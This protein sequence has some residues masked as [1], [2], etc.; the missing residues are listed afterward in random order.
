[1]DATATERAVLV[2]LSLGRAGRSA[3]PSIP[4][5]SRA[6]SSS[7]PQYRSAAPV[8]GR[9]DPPVRRGAR[10]RRGL[11]EVQP[12]LLAARLPRLPRVLLLAD[13]H[14]AALDEA[15]R[16]LRRL[17]PR[18]RRR[19]RSSRHS[20]GLARRGAD[21]RPLRARALPGA[22][23]PGH[24]RRDHRPGAGS[25]L[26]DATGGGLVT[27]EGSGHGPHARDPVK[28]NLLLRD[29]VE[30]PPPRAALGAR[31]VAPQ[32]RALR[33]LADR[34]RA[35][36]ARRRDRRRAAQAASRPRDRL[37][38]AAPGDG[39][40]RGARRADPSRR[41]RT[42]RTSRAT[43]RASRP[44][45]TCTASRRSG[46]WTR[47]CSRTSWSSTTSCATSSTTSGS[48]T[49]RGS[50]TTT[51]TRTPSRSAP[52]TSWLTDFVGWLPMPDGGER[53]AFLT[54]DYNAEMI[55]HIA[56]FP[57]VRDR[58]IFVGNPTTSCRTRSGPG[59]R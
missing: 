31:Q 1:M 52:P 58:A 3:R 18:D 8:R 42:W 14:R 21:A 17:G 36:A 30:P 35:R 39:G 41:A 13:V 48:A 44:S 19:R 27:L 49:R 32:A 54:A 53:E 51:C 11:G 22:G 6:S 45:T 40:A 9:V 59:C 7:G 56:R 37:A 10:H 24:G 20:P 46:G 38:R 29:F 26:A 5:A 55:E 47:S 34:A 16:G 50:S 57:R 28:V 12:A 43:S 15:D 23:D 25:A 2:S 4:S 33:L